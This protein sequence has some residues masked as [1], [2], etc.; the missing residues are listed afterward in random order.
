MVNTITKGSETNEEKSTL[1]VNSHQLLTIKQ[2]CTAFPWPSESAMRAYIYRASELGLNDAFFRVG[3][4]VLIDPSKFFLFIKQVE[5][6]SN[7][8]GKYET[9]LCNKGKSHG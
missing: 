4:R 1:S 8:G 9:T 2:F 3:R 5:S 7:P 6:R